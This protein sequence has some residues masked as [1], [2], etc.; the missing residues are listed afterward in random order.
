VR[1]VRGQRVRFFLLFWFLFFFIKHTTVTKVLKFLIARVT[2][3]ISFRGLHTTTNFF[4][5]KCV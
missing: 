3:R 5:I 1:H 4:Q 2:L